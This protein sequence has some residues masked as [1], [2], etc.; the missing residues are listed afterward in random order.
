MTRV[1]SYRVLGTAERYADAA[2]A[3]VNPGD[4]VLVE[5]AGQH[6]QFVMACPDGC[7]EILS[8][9]LDPRSGPAWRVYN[10]K[11]KWSLFPSVDRT[12][13][14]QS[15]FILWNGRVCW[16]DGSDDGAEDAAARLGKTVLA[17]LRQLHTV[18]YVQLA[19]VM[20]ELPWDVL[21]ACRALVRQD[22]LTEGSG[23]RRGTFSIP[24]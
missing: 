15:H 8:V 22:L 14:C 18:S 19:D 10:R 7:G 13:G 24:T 21:S 3:L 5:R 23:K 17:H 16:A 12:T 11:G 20:G 2:S 4:C 1:L 6:R 9:N